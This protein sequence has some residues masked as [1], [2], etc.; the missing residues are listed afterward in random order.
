MGFSLLFKIKKIIA[1]RRNR[2][3]HYSLL[4]LKN[5]QISALKIFDYLLSNKKS[6]VVYSAVA[7]NYYIEYKGIICKID[8]TR[9]IIT[10]GLYWYDVPMPYSIISN[11][12]RKFIKNVESRKRMLDGKINNKLA[13]SLEK[14]YKD[15]I[16]L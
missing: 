1:R 16:S 2:H 12:K 7:D 9:L 8:D 5:R 15:I 11:S 14:V 6:H 10:N 4:H 13:S 3:L